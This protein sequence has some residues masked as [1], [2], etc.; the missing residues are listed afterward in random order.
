MTLTRK[1][2]PCE[3]LASLEIKADQPL[4]FLEKLYGVLLAG[5]AALVAKTN[6]SRGSKL[7]R[8]S[9]RRTLACALAE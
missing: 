9:L 8:L 7:R 1:V 5:I 3:F 2:R 4:D 6:A